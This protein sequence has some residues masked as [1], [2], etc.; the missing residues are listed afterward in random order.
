MEPVA[1]SE[2]KNWRPL[3][4]MF[5]EVLR[6]ARNV[7]G[8][9]TIQALDYSAPMLE[10]AKRK[11]FG[12]G[13]DRIEFIHGDAADMPFQVVSQGFCGRPRGNDLRAQGSL[14]LPGC[15]RKELLYTG[16]N[17]EYAPGCGLQTGQSQSAFIGS[18]GTYNCS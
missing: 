9:T 5:N 17:P 18:S 6:M 13:L 3:E 7:N 14:P 10:V 11:A 16:V 8:R 12:K 2:K 15:L 4:K 1:K